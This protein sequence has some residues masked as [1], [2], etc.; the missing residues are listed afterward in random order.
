M[1]IFVTVRLL[2]DPSAD[3]IFE[4]IARFEL[5]LLAV[6]IFVTFAHDAVN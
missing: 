2:N 5:I 6:K 3:V 1:R 4:I